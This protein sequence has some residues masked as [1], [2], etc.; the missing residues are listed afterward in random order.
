MD[1][2]NY[3]RERI[4]KEFYDVITFLK[5]YGAKGYNKNWH[6]ARWEWLL[7]HSSLDE[8]SLPAIR[9]YMEDG[10]IAGLVTHDMRNPAYIILNPQY[11]WLKPQ[12]V[13]YA[14]KEHVHGG[15]VQLYADDNDTELI[16][17][18][19]E[20]GFSPK[21]DKE[22]ALVLVCDR[23]MPY[24][25][26]EPFSVRDYQTEKNM[27]RYEAVIHKGF[28]NKGV[29]L[30]GLT[31]ADFPEKPHDNPQ[32]A[33]FI[34]AADGEY[35]AHCGTWYTPDTDSCYVEPVVTIP[36]YRGRGLG[37]A[38]VYESINRCRSMGA[39]KAI[40][41]SD[42]PFYHRIGFQEYSVCHMWEKKI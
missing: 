9:L 14:V 16:S 12:M 31:E 27:D 13:D 29:P 22:C 35:A 38:A 21:A 1:I 3:P 33:V 39:E 7:S 36:S 19:K 41:I 24:D 20:K 26:E 23:E 10:E 15:A 28:G 6:W 42:Q 37:K 5:K 2:K 30:T 17:A 18:L 34:A 40:V 25:L 8:A 32:L 11:A 4:C